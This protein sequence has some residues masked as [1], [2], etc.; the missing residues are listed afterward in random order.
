M[1]KDEI[2]K[3][4]KEFCEWFEYCV[5]TGR[6]YSDA[7]TGSISR[8]RKLHRNI[9]E[10]E[11][12][13]VFVLGWFMVTIKIVCSC[14]SV[15]E[16]EGS[17]IHCGIEADRFLKNHYRCRVDKGPP[18]QAVEDGQSESVCNLCR[19]LDDLGNCNYCP[20]C[21]RKLRRQ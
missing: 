15:M 21:G 9:K 17:A 3:E 16:T 10:L 19:T 7:N 6:I 4:A 11:K 1:T 20:D 12:E 13:K 2:I 5:E 14:G 18:Q 8:V